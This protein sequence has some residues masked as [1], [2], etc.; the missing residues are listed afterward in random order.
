MR[1]KKARKKVLS[2]VLALCMLVGIL[3]TAGFAAQDTSIDSTATNVN[4]VKSYSAQMRTANTKTDYSVGGFT[5]DTEGKTDSWRYFNGVMMD[6]FLMEGD[7]AYADA[8]Y[9][10]NINEDGTIKKYHTGELDSVPTARGLFDLLNSS[11][12]EKYKKAIQYVYTQLENQVSYDSCG[13]NYLHKQDTSGKPTGGW[14]TWNIGL[15]GLYMAQP[16]LMECANA[17]DNGTLSL[18]DKN[19]APVSSADIYQAVYKRF[20][21]VADNMYDDTTGLYNH[22]WNVSENKGNGHFWGRGIGWYAMALVDTISMMPATYQT[23]MQPYLTKLF[24]GMLKYQDADTGMWYNVVNRKTDLSKNIL[25]TSV[26]SMMAYSLMKAYIKGYVTDAKY[27]QAGLAAF[28]GVVANKVTGSEGS[29]AVKDTYLKSGVGTTDEYYIA[30]GYTVDEAKGTGALIMAATVAKDT[31]EKLA[32]TDTE[33]KIVTDETTSVSVSGTTATAIQVADKS[34]DD[35]VK[36][37]LTGKLQSG[38]KAYD[39]TLTGYAEGTEATVTMPAPAGA[40]KVYYVAENGTLEEITGATF[41]D[42]TV[43]FT[44]THFSTYAAGT[45]SRAVDSGGSQNSVSDNGTLPGSTTYQ[46]VTNGTIE[47]GAEYLIVN[48]ASDGTGYA[49]R[50]QDSSTAVKQKVKISNSVATIASNESDC[51]WKFT[52]S[53][54]GYVISNGKRYIDLTQSSFVRTEPSVTTVTSRQNNIFWLNNGAYY[55]RYSSSAFGRSNSTNNTGRRN[56]YLFKKTV[57]TGAPVTLTVTPKS[58]SL[59]LGATANLTASVLVDNAAASS[60]EITWSSS[61]E[62]VATVANDGVVTAVADGTATITATLTRA[63]GLAPTE[64]VKVEIPITVTSKSVKSATLTGNN[65]VTTPKGVEPDFRNIKLNVTYD[66]NSTD[67]ITTE[68]G[69]VISDYDINEI[70]VHYATITYQGKEYGTVKVTVEGNPYEGLEKA[71]D[72]PEYPADG[73][74]RIDKTATGQNFNSTGVVQVELDTAGISVKKGVDVVLVVD[75]SNSMGWTDNWFEGMTADQVKT[76]TDADKIPTGSASTTTDKL[77]QAM[78]AAQEF[79]NILLADNVEGAATNNSISFVTFAGYDKDNITTKTTNYIDSVQTVFTNVQNAD[80]ANKAFANTQFTNYNVNGTKVTFDL[81]IGDTDGSVKESGT[82]RGNTNYDYAFAQANAAVNELK[83][84]HGGDEA[85]Q[86]SG[87]E[88]VVVFMTDGAPSHYNDERA[89]GSAADRLYGTKTEYPSAKYTADTWLKQLQK[90]N[91]YA[92][93]LKANINDFYAVGFD[94]NHGGF[95]DFSWTQ[96][97]LKPVLEGLAGENSVKVELAENGTALQKFYKS[98]ATQ[99]K[100]AGTNARVTDTVD[101]NFTL[102]TTSF[103]TDTPSAITVTAYDLYTK[104]DVDGTNVTEAM[105][106]TR[107]G[108]SPPLETVTFNEAG[109]EAYSDKLNGNIMTTDADGNVTIEAQ[110]FTYTKDAAGVE[111][112]V[113]NIGDIT[114]KEVALSYYAYLKGSMEGTCTKGVYYTNEGATLEY[115]DINGKYAAKEFPK[116]NVNWGGAITTIEYYLVNENGEPVNNNGIVIPFANRIK[117]GDDRARTFNWNESLTVNGSGYVPAGYDMYSPK[118]RYTVKANSDGSGSLEISDTKSIAGSKEVTTKRVDTDTD[119]YASTAVAFGVLFKGTPVEKNPLKADQIV[120]DYGK[121]IQ[122]DITSN[123]AA[124]AEYKVLGFVQYSADTN[125]RLT[126]FTNGTPVFNGDYGQ[127][128]I[129]DRKVQYQPK[130][131]LSAVEKI[132]AIIQ[133]S[134]TNGSESY[135]MLNELDII[136]ATSVYYETDFADGVFTLDADSQWETETV[137]DDI[138]ADPT[139]DDGTIG[140]NQYGYDR[141]YRNDKYQSNGS[142]YAVTGQGSTT[143]TANFS[144]T[145][146]GFDIISRTGSDEGFIRVSIYKDA[147]KTTL[148]KRVTVLN[149]SESNLELYQIPVVSIENLEHGTYYVEIGVSAPK[150]STEYPELSNQ[151]KFH[152]DAIRIYNPINASATAAEQDPTSDAAVARSAYITDGEADASVKEIRSMLI[153][154]NTFDETADTEDPD[155][156]EGVTFVDKTPEGATLSDYKTIGPN[157][158]VYLTSEQAIGFKIQVNKDSLPA[159]ID[160]GAKSANGDPVTLSINVLDANLGSIVEKAVEIQSSTAQY[161]DLMDGTSVADV[162]GSNDYVYI[163]IDNPG[164]GI[165]SITDL[166]IASGNEPASA[167]ILSDPQ[168]VKQTVDYVNGTQAD[169]ANYGIISA[170]F[171][172]E[173]IKRNKQA[174]LIVKTSDAVESLKVQNSAGRAVNSTIVAENSDDGTKV[175]TVTF[176][177]TS[178]GTQTFTV[179]GYGKDGTAGAS[180]TASIKVTAR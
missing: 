22:G 10:S 107:K 33:Q 147:E 58:A 123:E 129:V 86:A 12:Q 17:I 52:Q 134:P 119:N 142:S 31:A 69:L 146:T 167:Q 141:S 9:D 75:V 149:K 37:A 151:G 1:A 168:V 23:Q 176:K 156:T 50:N 133:V 106:G 71:T 127:F 82:N 30:N 81:Q 136:P 174:T 57:T 143:T 74:V 117:V 21:W 19:D 163:V 43:T 72:Y 157:N 140:N 44:T 38:F 103:G 114:D 111:K 126:Q 42:G 110:Y 130:K 39:I 116:P 102:Q 27:G 60:S 125:V 172:S 16:F 148:A 15:D 18:T 62:N 59:K 98:L 93:T 41:G 89:N 77:D 144:F 45:G 47:D 154:A 53:G 104:A 88:T 158:E 165:L 120:I 8:F 155:Y 36:T 90:P 138:V 161:F 73:A 3:P 171:T 54:S 94:L 101:S 84:K 28:N 65:A 159:S 56:V 34:D 20:A 92:Q 11:H 68:N 13:G 179:T 177:A 26:S 35:T 2:F 97:E 173:T 150:T 46:L 122:A 80:S 109:T 166:K 79:S 55:L 105:I 64:T 178:L 128:T 180:A 153:A 66:D 5:W 91:R 132:F 61:N 160:I 24:D 96:D 121:A 76:A 78:E 100:Y 175:W 95:S 85:Y 87:R 7:T 29:Y 63:N 4:T 164:E 70:G 83:N 99:I 131:M 48:T 49:L 32:G 40:D 170:E 115:V 169:E 112:F 108:T 162:F 14:S 135:R 137:N 145:G 6:A 113:W 118:A 25:E 67:V 51:V 124:G 152:F 139:Q